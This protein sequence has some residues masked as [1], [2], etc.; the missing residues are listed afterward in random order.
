MDGM[1]QHGRYKRIF[2]ICI[3]SYIHY[4]LL[5]DSVFL[6]GAKL[7]RR[8][9]SCTRSSCLHSGGLH[10]RRVVYSNPVCTTGKTR[11]M[12]YTLPRELAGD[13]R[14]ERYGERCKECLLLLRSRSY[15]GSITTS[16]YLLSTSFELMRYILWKKHHLAHTT[17]G[18]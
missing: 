11:T 15:H 5:I 3:A 14:G 18:E 17:T 10:L 8:T 7:W 13:I 4:V 9:S 1:V 16:S 2:L 12:E 6:D